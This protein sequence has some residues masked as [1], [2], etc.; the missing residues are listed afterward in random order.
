MKVYH[1]EAQED[2]DELMI[3]FEKKGFKWRGGEKPTKLNKFKKYRK[4]ICV[5]EEDGEITLSGIEYFKN[6]H[7]NE[8]LIEYK[9]KGE[10]NDSLPR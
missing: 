9:A 3:Y 6:N 8:T 7:S 10:N 4:D 2:Y 1:I 5:Y